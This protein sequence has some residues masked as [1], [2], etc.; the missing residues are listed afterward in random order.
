MDSPA[1]SPKAKAAEKKTTYMKFA[2]FL[3]KYRMVLFIAFG[4]AMLALLGV[5]IVTIVN[6]STLKASTTRMEKLDAD[7]AAYE[8]EQDKAKKVELEK[9][10]VDSADSVAKKYKN[11]FAGQRALSYE[12]RIAEAKKDW[13][14]AEKYWLSI[15]D[16]A[17]D[18][19]LAPV[20]LRAAARAAEEQNSADRAL[21]DYKK[22]VEKYSDKTIGIPHA[23]FSIGRLSEGAKDYSG[24][25]TAY[26][27]VVSSWPDSD[28]TKLA[29]D[30][31]LFMKSHG[32]SK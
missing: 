8:A 13:A 18:S 3:R 31:I 23:Y 20:A 29:T 4:A 1:Y 12:A 27:K 5:A 9:S 15:V 26:Q 21:S 14:G 28:W 22:L 32:L 24:A 19:Y 25:L 6:D 11:S 17:P 10:I 30:R 16:S 7:F 2:D